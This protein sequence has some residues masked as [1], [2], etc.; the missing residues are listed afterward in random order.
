MQQCKHN[1]LL[2]KSATN[3]GRE[4]IYLVYK[5]EISRSFL[6][7]PQH[8]TLHN[9]F[10]FYSPTITVSKNKN[11]ERL[12]TIPELLKTAPLVLFQFKHSQSTLSLQDKTK[13][14][15]KKKSKANL[16]QNNLSMVSKLSRVAYIQKGNS[17]IY[18]PH[19]LNA[20]LSQLESTCGTVELKQKKIS[21]TIISL[22]NL[23]ETLYKLCVL[24]IFFLS[25]FHARYYLSNE[26][27][28]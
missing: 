23:S 17:I 24:C 22:Q 4:T 6:A 9:L 14:T 13:A 1:L 20:N 25:I 27:R 2:S 15:T 8:N 26:E 19:S 5:L 21:K 11:H 10:C 7:S 18:F 16:G 3:L 12:F 28:I